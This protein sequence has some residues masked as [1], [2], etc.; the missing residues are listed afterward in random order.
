MVCKAV[1][2]SCWSFWPFLV[3]TNG[4][5]AFKLQN[6]AEN[7]WTARPQIIW[8]FSSQLGKMYHS[9]VGRQPHRQISVGVSRQKKCLCALSLF[10]W[11]LETIRHWQ[12]PGRV[13]NLLSLT[14]KAWYEVNVRV[15][16]YWLR[17]C[18]FFSVWCSGFKRGLW[19]KDVDKQ[20]FFSMHN[21]ICSRTMTVGSCAAKMFVDLACTGKEQSEDT[22]TS[23]FVLS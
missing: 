9:A 16:T 22:D 11:F 21:Y 19:V 7:P 4:D 8:A 14:T 17:E 1:H 23:I 12:C 13:R 18:H 15:S 10:L 20:I 2:C 3:W 5:F 6:F